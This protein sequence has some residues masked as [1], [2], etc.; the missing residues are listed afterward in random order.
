MSN[1]EQYYV[2]KLR[3]KTWQ[4]PILILLVFGSIFLIGNFAMSF[5]KQAGIKECQ[6]NCETQKQ[7]SSSTIELTK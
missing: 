4:L 7:D 3:K 6:E 1:N 5:G 2:I